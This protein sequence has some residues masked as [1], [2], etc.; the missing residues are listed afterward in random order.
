MLNSISF[1]TGIRLLF[2]SMSKSFSF[3]AEISSVVMKLIL[4]S[5]IIENYTHVGCLCELINLLRLSFF[6]RHGMIF[7][8]PLSAIVIMREAKDLP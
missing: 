7:K 1:T 2:F 3:K 4:I 5:S 8:Y 6:L